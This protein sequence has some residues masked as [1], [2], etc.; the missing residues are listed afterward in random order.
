MRRIYLEIIKNNFKTDVFFHVQDLA[1]FSNGRNK[2][3]NEFEKS[4]LWFKSWSNF[5][6]WVETNQNKLN[7]SKT[8]HNLFQ[9][10]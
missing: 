8:I 1:E 6:K 7:Q 2:F 10:H 3:E 4:N 5:F 9:I